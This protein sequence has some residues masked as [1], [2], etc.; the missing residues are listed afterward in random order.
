M[1]LGEFRKITEHYDDDCTLFWCRD[2]TTSYSATE[3]DRVVIDFAKVPD[4]QHP[5]IIVL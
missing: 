2:L 5:D 3:V 4:L 1:T